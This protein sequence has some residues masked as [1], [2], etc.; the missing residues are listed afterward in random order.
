MDMT[1]VEVDIKAILHNIKEAR[2]KLGK[3]VKICAVI[4]DNAYGHG[5][6]PV[7]AALQ[8]GGVESLGI[9]DISEAITLRKNGIKLPILNLVSTFPFQAKDIVNNRISQ[10]VSDLDIVR[11]LDR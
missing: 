1:W 8:K 3:G 6:I 11:A 9:G 5:L 10:S 2:R 7:A 4:K